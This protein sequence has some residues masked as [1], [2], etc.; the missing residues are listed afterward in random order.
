[1]ME[2]IANP[3]AAKLDVTAA[4][5]K[6]L[7]AFLEMMNGFAERVA[8]MDAYEFAT[9]MMRDTGV[10]REAKADTTPEG[11]ARL[12]NLEEML[13]G[14]H[15]FVEQRLR[16]GVSFTPMT[17]FLSEV[18]LLTDQDENQDDN[19]ARI[20]LLTVHAAKGLE[21]KV[22][23]I[24]GLE[25]NLF[26]SQ[27]CQAPKEIEEERRLLYVGLSCY[28]TSKTNPFRYSPSG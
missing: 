22:T 14:I 25:E 8:T 24:V 26:P 19:Q 18:S 20:T 4:T 7:T 1:M 9:I 21:F 17:E 27:F 12:E 28:S 13:A 23:F 15:E 5:M 11:V 2:A 3:E 6:K 10:M 16:D